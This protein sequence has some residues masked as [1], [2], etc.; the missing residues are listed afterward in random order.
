MSDSW[1]HELN[2]RIDGRYRQMVE[3]RRRLH[4][5]PE[6]SGDERQTSLYLYQLFGD[7]GFHVRMG[8]DGRGALVDFPKAP[9]QTGQGRIALRAD[10]DA[11]RIHDAKEVEYRSRHDGVMH[12]CGHDAHTAIAVGALCSLKDLQSAGR[13][14]WEIRLRGIFQ[15]SEETCL[16]AMEMIRVGALDGVDAILA[17]H[18]DPARRLGRIG[19]RAGVFTASSDQVQANIVGRGGHAARPHEASDPIAAAAQLINALYLFVPRATDSQDAVVIT[20]GQL[21]GGDNAN[22]IPEE[23]TLRGTIRT[24]EPDVRDETFDHIRRLATGIGQTTD[25]KIQ[26]RF[27]QSAHSIDNDTRLIELLVRSATEILGTQGI[28]RIPRPSMGS[29][30]F[31]FYAEKTPGAMFRLGCTSDQTGGFPLHSPTFDIDEEALR[32]GARILARTVVYW[33]DPDSRPKPS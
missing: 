19:L 22:V 23:V 5:Y 17:A 33:C 9:D 21:I 29:E 26:V 6:V 18:M 10:I 13:L 27:E 31:A 2:R 25:T 16:G 32:V 20:I 12:A 28:E 24:L 7:E 8:P 14:P 4:M 15:P 30:D 11:L 3:I 1:Q